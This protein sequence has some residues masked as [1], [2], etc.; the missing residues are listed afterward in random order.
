MSTC[1]SDMESS[2]CCIFSS[3]LGASSS[4]R[5]ALSCAAVKPCAAN[6]PQRLR[7]TAV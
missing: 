5:K 1:D 7:H 6:G 3:M 2:Y 4:S